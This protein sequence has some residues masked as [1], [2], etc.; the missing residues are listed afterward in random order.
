MNLKSDMPAM[1]RLGGTRS[2]VGAAFALLLLAIFVYFAFQTGYALLDPDEARY[3]EIAREMVET[4]DMVTPRLNGVAYF[5]KPPLFYWCLAGSLCLFDQPE[6]AVRFVPAAAGVLT[7]L[8]VVVL[9]MHMF[10]LKTGVRAGWIHLT[11]LLPLAMARLPII[12]GL[13]SLLLMAT[14]ATWWV[15]YRSAVARSRKSCFLAAWACL[16]LATMTKGIAAIAMTALIVFV[17]LLLRRDLAALKGMYWWRGL[18]VFFLITLPWH[19]AAYLKTPEYAHFYFVVQHFGRL[20]GTEH[21]KPLWFFFLAF[22]AGMMFWGLFLFPAVPNLLRRSLAAL[23]VRKPVAGIVRWQAP[24]E[25]EGQPVESLFLLVWLCAVIGI[26]SLSRC[27]LLPY[28]LPASPAAALILGSYLRGDVLERVSTRLCPMVLAL[29]ILGGILPASFYF[30]DIQDTVPPEEIRTSLVLLQLG[31]AGGAILLFAAISRPRFIPA[32]FG[33]V[34]LFLLP[35]LALGVPDVVR[36]RKMGPLAKALPTLPAE[37]KIAE[38]RSYSRS[39]GFYAGR[40]VI[41]IDEV[42]ELDFGRRLEEA[43]PYFRKGRESLLRLA[44]EGPVLINLRREDW[45]EIAPLGR[46]ELVSANYGNTLV[47][48]RAFFNVTGLS[49]WPSYFLN[50]PPIYLPPRRIV[51]M[52]CRTDGWKAR[53][54]GPGITVGRTHSHPH[55]RGRSFPEASGRS[56]KRLEF[57]SGGLTGCFEFLIQNPAPL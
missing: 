47:A 53:T 14:W 29:V 5:E 4:G 57:F 13:F 48:N 23:E 10:D 36:Y 49:P 20:L 30:P 15:G 21:V 17:F 51:A 52:S 19:V 11:S 35:G 16:G 55:G 42:S 41:L 7:L 37:V 2:G 27:K 46:F 31:L 40:R 9:G 24:P 8:L 22:P 18:S 38:W 39:L 26:F 54:H 32:A 28:V 1:A 12:D 6:R 25:E 44:H 33:L 3:A 56:E 34:L 43:S 50:E 45:S